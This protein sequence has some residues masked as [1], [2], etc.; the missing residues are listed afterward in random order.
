MG[1]PG[2]KIRQTG[3]N[4][5]G[6]H[7]RDEREVDCGDAQ[8]EGQA[9]E[10]PHHERDLRRRV[11]LGD[12][13]RADGD[14]V[15]HQRRQ[16]HRAQDDRVAADREHDEPQRQ[17]GEDA[18]HHEGGDEQGLVGD[19]VEPRTQLRTLVEVAR[20]PAVHPVGDARD[21]EGEEADGV[22]AHQQRPYRD[23]H[24]AEAREGDE[25]G[26]RHGWGRRSGGAGK[27]AMASR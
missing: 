21:E 15:R 20:D 27:V 17:L 13:E 8:S 7:R 14:R 1:A 19:G 26:K 25:V 18:Q 2:A 16:Q 22:L 24:E 3:E 12:E 9:G 5:K 6:R 4:R 11:E 10:R 23:G